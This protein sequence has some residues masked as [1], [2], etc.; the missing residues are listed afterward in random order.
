VP[1]D[2]ALLIAAVS[3]LVAIALVA[4]FGVAW[5]LDRRAAGTLEPSSGIDAGLITIPGP[6]PGRE[7]ADETALNSPR[8]GLTAQVVRV[9]SLVFLATVGAATAISQQWRN[10]LGI[11]LLVA[12]GTL[13]V[14]LVEDLVPGIAPGR[15]RYWVIATVS[16]G[17]IAILTALTGRLQSPYVA[18]YLLI[19]AASAISTRR[20]LPPVLALVAAIAYVGVS[21]PWGTGLTADQAALMGFTLVMLAVIAFIAA[22]V[23]GEMRRVREAALRLSRF[24]PLTGLYNR[25]HFQAALDREIRRSTRTNRREFALLMLDLDELKPVNDTYG[26]QVGDQLIRGLATVL[27]RTVRTTDTAA[28]YGGDEFAVL[29]PETNREGA[30]AVAEKLRRDSEALAERGARTTVSIG[31]VVYPHDGETVERL[32]TEADN[33]LYLAKKGGK[34]RVVGFETRSERVATDNGAS[35]AATEPFAPRPPTLVGV[36]PGP[37]PSGPPGEPAPWET[38][39]TRSQT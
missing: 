32:L 5:Y 13:F 33:A 6:G 17:F 31:L 22:V 19:V 36:G 35:N 9:V 39:T 16:I 28:R 23:G 29:L 38:R 18:G 27:Q 8:P 24:D 14:V 10:E 4:G 21:F 11:Y 15:R 7:P 1:T 34:N 25:R 20:A 30:M 2:Q 26:H 37:R 12:A 3:A